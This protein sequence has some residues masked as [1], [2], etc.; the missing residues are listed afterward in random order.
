MF[1]KVL[2]TPVLAEAFIRFL[3]ITKLPEKKLDA[4]FLIVE[5]LYD[6]YVKK[7]LCGKTLW[8]ME[9]CSILL[10]YTNMFMYEKLILEHAHEKFHDVLK[11]T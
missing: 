5:I 8:V 3:R 6:S 4:A 9:N 10:M 7:N 1:N 2:H 11:S